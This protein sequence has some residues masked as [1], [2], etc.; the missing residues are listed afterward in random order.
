MQNI[1]WRYSN[2][3]EWSAR[4]A[5]E[6]R[7]GAMDWNKRL[8]PENKRLLQETNLFSITNVETLIRQFFCTYQF[9]VLIPCI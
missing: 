3:A 2:L 8:L 4:R 6:N 9:M 5:N 1:I 7:R